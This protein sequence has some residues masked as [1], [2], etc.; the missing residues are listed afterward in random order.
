M[1]VFRQRLQENFSRAAAEYDARARFQHMETLRV[2]DA[3]LMLFPEAAR[4]A[5]IGCGTGY[6]SAAARVRR[7]DWQILGIDIASGMCEVAATRCSAIAG[8]AAHLPL[9]S[10]SV[11]AAVSSLCYQWVEKQEQAFA[12]LHR[13]M[14]PGARAIIAS[15]G[16]S[17][18]CELRQSMAA[19]DLP[20]GLLPMRAFEPTRD[21]LAAIGFDI[22]LAEK[23]L[24]TEHYADV[25]ALLDS[26]RAIG[27]GNNFGNSARGLMGPKRWAA[28]LAQYEKLRVQ[29]GIP[30]TWE[31]HFFILHKPQ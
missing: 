6:F 19:A 3:A 13:V 14:K 11:D 20:L 1:Q 9:A 18:L 5:D 15:L 27:A 23:R 22:V 7:P 28:M 21:I 8:D 12:E 2:L 29:P 4:I 16:E 10:A 30:A 26:M 25:P 24:V 17:T 31:H